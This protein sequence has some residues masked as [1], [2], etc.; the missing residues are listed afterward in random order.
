MHGFIVNDHAY[1]VI[2]DEVCPRVLPRDIAQ[3]TPEDRFQTTVA[4]LGLVIAQALDHP[5]QRAS[6]QDI[7]GAHS[8]PSFAVAIG[9][10][11]P[12]AAVLAHQQLATR[13]VDCYFAGFCWSTKHFFGQ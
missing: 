1:S 11:Q 4:Q 9:K 3:R 7:S 2:A 6:L 12:A 13:S 10:P 5:L 8:P